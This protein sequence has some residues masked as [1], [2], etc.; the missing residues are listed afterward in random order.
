MILL[1]MSKFIIYGETTG[2]DIFPKLK[3]SHD[4]LENFL[5]CLT[6]WLAGRQYFCFMREMANL[7]KLYKNKY[8]QIRRSPFYY[9]YSCLLF[10][11]IIDLAI[12]ENDAMA[13]LEGKW[14]ERVIGQG[15]YDLGGGYKCLITCPP[16]SPQ[17]GMFLFVGWTFS[18]VNKNWELLASIPQVVQGQPWLTY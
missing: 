15:F 10:S 7:Q 13:F 1:F 3:L 9:L 5:T 16:T 12:S 14:W 17:T 8:R 4:K 18:G 6:M 2:R 11:S